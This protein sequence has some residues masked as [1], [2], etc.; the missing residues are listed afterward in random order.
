MLAGMIFDPSLLGFLNSLFSRAWWCMSVV[1][2]FN[3]SERAGPEIAQTSMA[4]SSSK[5]EEVGRKAG[6]AHKQ[7]YFVTATP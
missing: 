7:I 1:P 3:T 5:A 6:N 4:P 2:D